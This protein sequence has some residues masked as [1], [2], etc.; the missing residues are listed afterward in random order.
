M[1]RLSPAAANAFG[2]QRPMP[3]LILTAIGTDRPGL[4]ETLAAAVADHGGNWAKGRMARLGG[5]FAGIVRV[6]VSEADEAGLR[7]ALEALEGL[8][9]TVKSDSV[10]GAPAGGGGA[11]ARLQFTGADR[12][13]IVSAVSRALAARGVNVENLDTECLSAPMSGEP[14]FRA[15]ADLVLPAGLGLDDLRAAVEAVAP[16]LMVDLLE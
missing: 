16:D 13:G 6:F 12:S 5:E 10:A 2:V 15:E 4:V 1:R 11:T 8:E 3:S 7:T 14:L 9:V